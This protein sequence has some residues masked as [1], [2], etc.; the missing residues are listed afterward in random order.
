MEPT[1]YPAAGIP[2]EPPIPVYYPPQQPLIPADLVSYTLTTER[3]LGAAQVDN[4][5]LQQKLAQRAL[6]DEAFSKS[7]EF[8]DQRT[9]TIGPSGACLLLMN[10]Q[11]DQVIHVIPVRPFTMAPFYLIWFKNRENCVQLDEKTYLSDKKLLAALQE[12]QGLEITVRKS[13]KH[14]A[15]LLRDAFSRHMNVKKLRFYEGWRVF[16]SEA[17]AFRVFPNFSTHQSFAE[18]GLCLDSDPVGAFS[19]ALAATAARQ[20]WPC[21]TVITGPFLR[22]VLFLWYHSALLHS[23][24]RRLGFEFPLAL[25]ILAPD[26]DLRLYIQRLYTWFGDIPFSLDISPKNFT[27]NLL[28]RKDQPVVILDQG[29]LSN[30]A[31]NTHTL[32]EVLSTGEI[33]FNG[34]ARPVLA[35]LT[36]ISACT[37]AIGCAPETIDLDLSAEDFSR[38]KWLTVESQIAENRD[39]LTAFASFTQEHIPDLYSALEK[40]QKT[41]LRGSR[42]ELNAKCLSTFGI[43]LGLLDFLTKFS[44][45]CAPVIPPIAP[46]DKSL[47]K[48]LFE[49]FCQTAEKELSGGIADQFIAVARNQ[50]QYGNI[51]IFSKKF[52]QSTGFHEHLLCGRKLHLLHTTCPSVSLSAIAAK[53]TSYPS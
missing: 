24:F 28:A 32:E 30:A 23:L 13:P 36:V 10:R 4:L 21:F 3:C 19:P 1:N 46:L 44:H 45:F 22:H 25:Y 29:H 48:Q 6:R 37:S 41:V 14:T 7:L 31:T 42:G 43:F 33:T 5:R 12:V 39:Y 50:I 53:P 35:P 2:A 18:S 17:P 9:Y 27:K 16:D 26:T 51:R 20:F 34:D 47:A 15:M 52:R 40:G 8:A 38:E 11:V 49:L